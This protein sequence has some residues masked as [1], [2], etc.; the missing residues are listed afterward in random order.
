MAYSPIDQ[1][2]LARHAALEG[3][4]RRL[5]ASAATVALAWL[6]HQGALAIPKAVT[7]EHLRDNHAALTLELDAL[8]LRDIDAAFAPPRA[9]TA[10][11]IN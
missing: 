10:L 4:G 8:A 1:A 5:G 6:V 3:I 7:S 11:A 9:P 2:A